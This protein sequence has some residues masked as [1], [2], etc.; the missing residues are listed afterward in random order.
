MAQKTVL[1]MSFTPEQMKDFKLPGFAKV[2]VID[3]NPCLAV[4]STKTGSMN[5]VNIPF[6]YS[7]YADYS[8]VITVRVKFADVSKPK[9]NWNGTKMQATYVI[10]SG[11][12]W[13][14]AGGG[15][16][17][18]ADWHE[19]ETSFIA[20]KDIDKEGGS[21]Q[22]GTMMPLLDDVRRMPSAQ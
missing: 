8:V 20:P 19:V 17:G 22:L 16:S 18:T 11:R 4:T 5:T 6:D 21:I 1:D 13:K 3:G 7:K 10:P 14:N 15:E 12:Q 2:D 9:D